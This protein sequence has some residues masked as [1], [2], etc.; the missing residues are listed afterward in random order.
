MRIRLLVVGAGGFGGA[1]AEAAIATGLYELAGFA[2]DRWPELQEVLAGPVISR[3]TD[4]ATL[5]HR[6]Q[7]VTIAIGNNTAREQLFYHAKAAGFALPAIIH[8][9]AYVA[10]GATVGAGALVMAGALIG[11]ACTLG[12]GALIN[13]GAV[14]DHDC[15]VGAFAHVG[16]AASMGGGTRLGR[17]EVLLQADTLTANAG[18]R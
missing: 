4:L 15:E 10:Q 13:A 11:T 14:L 2:D 9:R 17:G 7:A 6:V 8:P 18:R 12:D 16:I 3:V 1:V 5:R